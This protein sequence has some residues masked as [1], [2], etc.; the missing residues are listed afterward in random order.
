M[1]SVCPIAFKS[2]MRPRLVIM[3]IECTYTYYIHRSREHVFD[4][5]PVASSSCSCSSFCSALELVQLSSARCT[6]LLSRRPSIRVFRSRFPHLHLLL[7]VSVLFVQN[8]ARF[9]FYLVI[10][11]VKSCKEVHL[12]LF[13]LTNRMEFIT[14][15]SFT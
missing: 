12:V 1:K 10:P 14:S 15:E 3:P 5:S 8:H 4:V 2:R 13:L 7:R 11:I 6:M 9:F